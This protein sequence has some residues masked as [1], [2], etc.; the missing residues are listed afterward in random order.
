MNEVLYLDDRY[1]KKVDKGA[2]NILFKVLC[3]VFFVGVFYGGY[4]SQSAENE[5]LKKVSATFFESRT[6]K[7]FLSVFLSN[8]LSGSIF[9][10]ILF[11]S[12]FSAIG[13]PLS[14]FTVF[15]TG[16][17]FGSAIGNIYLSQGTKGIWFSILLLIPSYVI[18]GFA[19]LLSARESVK[20]SNN[21]FLTLVRSSFVPAEK[22][23]SRYI[24]KFAVIVLLLFLSALLG[25]V[26]GEVFKR[27]IS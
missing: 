24:K 12:G 4:I 25:G 26:T 19:V 14:I 17:G 3:V 10:G 27:L 15:F 16:V 18:M 23:F 20:L 1:E 22:V 6:D 11:L 9:T 2:K 8:L 13:Q 7:D 21:L 5:I